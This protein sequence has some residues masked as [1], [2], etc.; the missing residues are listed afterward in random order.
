MGL[1]KTA[2]MKLNRKYILPTL[3]AAIA[4]GSYFAL[5]NSQNA[6]KS[7]DRALV[8]VTVPEL[9]ALAQQ[10][11]EAFG[12][13]CIACHGA[14]AAGVDGAGP[15]LVH[16]I[17]EPSHHGDMAIALAPIRG[18]QRHHWPFGDMPPVEGITE[19]EILRILAY[20]RELQRAN[21]IS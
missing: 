17:Y 14:N 5:N 2:R 1:A 12:T 4:G 15:P 18:V 19:D 6:P 11:A 9:S 21:G 13:H 16:K 3:I 8:E 10:G 20:I 7:T